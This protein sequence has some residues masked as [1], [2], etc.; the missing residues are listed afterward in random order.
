MKK[1]DRVITRAN[2]P[3]PKYRSRKGTIQSKVFIGRYR[4]LFDDGEM[5]YMHRND[6][7]KE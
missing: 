3:N 5:K 7:E 4:V 2:I 6:L 1:G